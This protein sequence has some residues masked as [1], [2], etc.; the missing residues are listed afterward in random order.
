MTASLILK[1]L[2][3]FTFGPVFDQM[4][5]WIVHNAPGLIFR[6]FGR[7]NASSNN[8]VSEVPWLL[9]LKINRKNEVSFKKSAEP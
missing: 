4:L 5:V 3:Y 6:K 2:P 9:L 7:R 1:V 8:S